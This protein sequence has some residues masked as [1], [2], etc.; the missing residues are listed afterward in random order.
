MAFRA[1]YDLQA[2]SSI[3]LG[4]SGLMLIVA[5]GAAAAFRFFGAARFFAFFV[6]FV[7][8]GERFVAAALRLVLVLRPLL[9]A[10]V[11]FV[12]FFFALRAIPVS[13]NQPRVGSSTRGVNGQ[14]T[15]TFQIHA[16][17]RALKQ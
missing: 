1:P 4:T 16:R 5:T 2:A 14:F 17:S 9:F 6:R 10:D 8:A 11:F 7:F 15:R 12:D 3:S 13:F